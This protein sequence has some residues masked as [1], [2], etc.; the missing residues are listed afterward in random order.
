M[1]EETDVVCSKEELGMIN[2]EW[3]RAPRWGEDGRI[4]A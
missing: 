1:R 2:F 3:S 4:G